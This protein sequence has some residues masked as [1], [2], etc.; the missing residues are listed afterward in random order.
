MGKKRDRSERCTAIL[1]LYNLAYQAANPKA[2]YLHCAN[3]P[4]SNIA[5]PT[6]GLF[7]F[8]CSE[9][10]RDLFWREHTFDDPVE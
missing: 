9:K 3:R 2:K 4:C 6:G 5:H 10:C 8:F 1:N 7:T